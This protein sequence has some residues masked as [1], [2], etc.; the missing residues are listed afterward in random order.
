MMRG[1]RLGAPVP[2]GLAPTAVGV[3]WKHFPQPEPHHVPDP[4]TGALAAAVGFDHC[5]EKG[6]V[7]PDPHPQA[8]ILPS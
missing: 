7:S 5:H 4:K 1:V 6:L 2:S 3:N 8:P